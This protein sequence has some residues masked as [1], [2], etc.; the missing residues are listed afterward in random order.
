MAMM[1]ENEEYS[2][3]KN[4]SK[5]YF[6][7]YQTGMTLRSLIFGY[8][9]DE[10]PRE[11]LIPAKHKRKNRRDRSEDRVEKRRRE[12]REERRKVGEK[13]ASRDGKVEFY[14]GI[15]PIVR[16]GKRIVFLA[17]DAS[18]LGEYFD[19]AVAWGLNRR[20]TRRDQGK[21][22]VMQQIKPNDVV[23]DTGWQGSIPQWINSHVPIT[24]VLLSGD[25]GS[26]ADIVV[27]SYSGK[28]GGKFREALVTFEHSPK[29]QEN[30]DDGWTYTTLD[31]KAQTRARAFRLGFIA[32][33]NGFEKPY[34]R[35]KQRIAR[36]EEY[37]RASKERIAS[38]RACGKAYRIAMMRAQ[39]AGYVRISTTWNNDISNYSYYPSALTEGDMRDLSNGY[40]YTGIGS[41]YVKREYAQR[42]CDAYNLRYTVKPRFAQFERVVR[43][44]RVQAWQDE[45]RQQTGNLPVMEW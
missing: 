14:R 7:G 29:L 30:D 1:T 10:L 16:S 43:V 15:L 21:E 36:R 45:I 42:I 6:E 38:Y 3:G 18:L 37:K 33:L 13:N 4:V 17:R 5:L 34:E 28:N 40:S 9:C 11:S 41:A 39:Y 24:S 44:T 27:S 12:I 32:G 31:R 26:W 25:S 19:C 23:I 35:E 2:R 8:S 20:A 22:L